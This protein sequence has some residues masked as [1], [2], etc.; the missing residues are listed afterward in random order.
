M[1]R[2][3]FVLAVSIDMLLCS[4]SITAVCTPVVFLTDEASDTSCEA[5]HKQPLVTGVL[6]F[7]VELYDYPVWILQVLSM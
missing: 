1:S 3:F 6:G 2:I 4:I 5:S 7:S